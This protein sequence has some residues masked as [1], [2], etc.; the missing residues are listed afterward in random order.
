MED[1]R[2]TI[3][4]RQASVAGPHKQTCYVYKPQVKAIFLKETFPMLI[5]LGPP[6][7]VPIPTICFEN[8]QLYAQTNQNGH[9]L[10]YNTIP[11]IVNTYTEEPRKPNYLKS[12]HLRENDAS[13]NYVSDNT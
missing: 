2:L 10:T 12:T 5:G 4:K 11:K 7:H 9:F 6:P 3:I 13:F 1:V 8:L